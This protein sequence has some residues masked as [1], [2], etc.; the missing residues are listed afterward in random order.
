MRNRS[1][2]LTLITLALLVAG[3][4]NNSTSSFGYITG[5][6]GSKI[7]LEYADGTKESIGGD[8]VLAWQGGQL[9]NGNYFR[10]LRI[11]TDVGS[12]DFR[13]SIPNGTSPD[14]VTEGKHELWE[15]RLL[16]QDTQSLNEVY[17]ELFFQFSDDFDGLENASG[18]VNIKESITKDGENYDI[19][20][21]INAEIMDVN[22]VL[23]KIKG[24]FWLRE[25]D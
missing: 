5:D 6:E 20:G 1:G 13:L 24:N 9:L 10:Q 3:C 4:K 21:E 19:A 18:T 2:F 22:G 25:A 15:S 8:R 16:L 23:V 11:F 12:L 17:P 7:T 14:E